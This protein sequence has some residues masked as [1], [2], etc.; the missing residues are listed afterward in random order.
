ME[1]KFRITRCSR[2]LLPWVPVG[3]SASKAAC[4][5]RSKVS[6]SAASAAAAR[7]RQSIGRS[8]RR[9]STRSPKL[10]TNLLILPLRLN[11][12]QP[13]V[14]PAKAGIQA[15]FKILD[16]GSRYPGL[17]PGLPGMT[18]QKYVAVRKEESGCNLPPIFIDVAQQKVRAPVGL[19]L[20]QIGNPK[21]FAFPAELFVRVF[22]FFG[23]GDLKRKSVRFR[24]IISVLRRQHDNVPRPGRYRN[25]SRHAPATDDRE[26][27]HVGQELVAFCF[28]V[29][30][31][32]PVG[33]R[34]RDVTASRKLLFTERRAP[35]RCRDLA[36]LFDGCRIVIFNLEVVATR[37]FEIDRIR[38]M[39]FVRWGYAFD[40]VL[41][42]VGG[43]VFIRFGN[44]LRVRDPEAI[45]V[46]M[47]FILTVGPGL[48]NDQTPCRVGMFDGRLVLRA[49]NH[50]G[51]Q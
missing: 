28:V 24:E 39:R 48:M 7:R 22:D 5:L 25:V 32:S 17:D 4:R 49:F 15:I 27:Q 16:S 41:L 35:V 9:E 30:I 34:L 2:K 6:A 14:I 1:P 19:E 50:L 42:L 20:S 36:A 31:E 23:S 33:H 43:K 45:V 13:D 51:G 21:L 26:S 18:T 38:K 44:F 10:E 29:A 40:L 8:S 3:S 47:R 12:L 37:L 11:P 46:G